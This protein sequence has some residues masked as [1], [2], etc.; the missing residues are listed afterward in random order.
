MYSSLAAELGVTLVMVD[1]RLS[2]ETQFPGPL[3]DCYAAL[4]WMVANAKELNI[5]PKR[6]GVFGASAGAT[7]AAG[8]ALLA[9]DRDGIPL[10]HVHLTQPMLDDRTSV[11][12]QLSPYVGEFGWT[13]ES[14][15]VGWEARLGMA[16]GA[17]GVS[18]YAAPGRMEDLSGM[19][20]TFISCGALDLF[21]EESLQFAQRLI[22]GGVP[23]E[24]HIYPG[25]PHGAPLGAKGPLSEAMIRDDLTAWRRGLGILPKQ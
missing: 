11:D 23:T 3:E 18:P 2:P 24:L 16:P 20:P 15:A 25:A 7:L 9:R 22:R 13:R 21:A 17:V 10:A 5:D 19:A 6:I 12:P 1:Y 14:N 4:K 8:V